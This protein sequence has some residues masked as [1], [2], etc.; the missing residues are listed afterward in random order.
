MVGTTAKAPRGYF[1]EKTV[2]IWIPV[3]L[4]ATY[5]SLYFFGPFKSFSV[6]F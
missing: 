2:E 1:E 4:A 6:Y 3:S 5:E